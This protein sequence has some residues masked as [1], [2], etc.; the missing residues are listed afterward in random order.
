MSDTHLLLMSSY[1]YMSYFYG[2]MYNYT[3][4]MYI[5]QCKETEFRVKKLKENSV[6]RFRVCAHTL[7]GQ[8]EWAELDKDVKATDPYGKI[9]Y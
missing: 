7:D 8:G 6:Y 3:L 5:G 1:M 2:Q 9:V 4:Y